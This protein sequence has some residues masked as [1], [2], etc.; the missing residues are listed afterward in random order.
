MS[1]Y[2]IKR[3]QFS[4]IIDFRNNIVTE[5][6]QFHGIIIIAVKKQKIIELVAE[7]LRW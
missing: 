6:R 7:W 2:L 5:R 1:R 4:R 3:C